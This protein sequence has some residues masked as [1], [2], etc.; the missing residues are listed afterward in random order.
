MNRKKNIKKLALI[1]ILG[2]I[3]ILAIYFAYAKYKELSFLTQEGS[4]LSVIP[5]RASAENVYYFTHEAAPGDTIEN[6]VRVYNN[7]DNEI[8]ATVAVKDVIDQFYE[9]GVSWS[10]SDDI[11]ESG[12]AKWTEL[13]DTEVTIP[14]G[15]M[16]LVNFTLTV[17]EDAEQR[18]YWGGITAE[19]AG[20]TQEEENVTVSNVVQIG[21]RFK[22]TV[23]DEPNDLA[24]TNVADEKRAEFKKKIWVKYGMISVIITILAIAAIAVL[25]FKE[26]KK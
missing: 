16:G 5:D 25:Q 26:L 7:F 1:L 21:A 8:I 10:F 9:D 15:T 4:G 20:W 22:L 13:E 14:A 11:S 12:I 3:T 18:E 6:G 24:N 17:P 19:T 2:A 23:T